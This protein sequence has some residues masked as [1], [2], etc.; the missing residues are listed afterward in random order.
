MVCYGML[1]YTILITFSYSPWYL[2]Q[3]KVHAKCWM[4]N[5]EQSR[6]E[7]YKVLTK[8]GAI[9]LLGWDCPSSHLLP[10]LNHEQSLPSLSKASHLGWSFCRVTLWPGW[11]SKIQIP[12][13]HPRRHSSC[14]PGKNFRATPKGTCFWKPHSPPYPTM[15]AVDAF[16]LSLFR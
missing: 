14:L 15:A 10:W 13:F 5:R 6:G 3:C 7:N 12:W 4:N 8:Q 9:H 1:W 11:L 2:R 16:V